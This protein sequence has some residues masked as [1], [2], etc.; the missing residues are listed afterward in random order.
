MPE[1]RPA[2]GQPADDRPATARRTGRR[3]TGQR[4]VDQ[5]TDDQADGSQAATTRRPVKRQA[6]GLRRM[7]EILDA[8]EGVIAEAGY[9]DMTTNAVAERA[10]MSPGSLY[11]FFRNKEEIL[12]GLLDR[13]TEGGARTGRP[14]SPAT[15]YGCPR[16]T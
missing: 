7:E 12:D 5:A 15:S 13:F 10:G 16:P 6:R 9:A 2:T 14:G 1:K 8:A 4:A 11:Q 3:A